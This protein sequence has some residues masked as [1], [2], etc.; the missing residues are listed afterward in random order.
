MA[1]I[2]GVALINRLDLLKS[3]FGQEAY[4]QV[5]EELDEETRDKLQN[6]LFSS[7]YDAEIFKK[8]NQAIAKVMGARQPSISQKIGE[9]TAE[10]SLKGVYS[11]KL[12]ESD[13]KKTLDRVTSLY[14]AFHDSGELELEPKEG[15]NTIMRV[16][17]YPLPHREFCENL[18]GW[19]RRLIELAGG[20]NVKI[21]ETSC[22]CKG[23]KHCEWA[24]SWD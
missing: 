4:N 17:G 20:K 23:D 22:V 15:N 10:A 9:L 1:G 6:L 7:W 12:K 19:G 2:K 18:T 24:A 14:R 13:V 3:H 8:L 16:K 5:M 21:V 11:S